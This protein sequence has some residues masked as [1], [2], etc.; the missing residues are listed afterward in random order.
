M[1]GNETVSIGEQVVSSTLWMGSWRW[2]ARL[3]GFV[4][5]II[6]ARLLVPEDFGVLATGAI[7]IG[8]FTIMTGL[9]SDSYLIRLEAPD[10][11]D[12]DT[13]WTLRLIVISIA[14][15]AVFFAAQPGADYFN[16]QRIAA[17]LQVLALT[18]WLG[19][20]VNIGLTIYRRDL[21]FR[22]IAIIG[23]SQRISGSVTTIALAFWLKM[24][25]T[26]LSTIISFEITGRAFWLLQ[27][28]PNQ[29]LALVP[30]LTRC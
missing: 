15:I 26:C 21:Q 22:K 13:A 27:I 17:V 5:T 20:L 2:S 16:D 7:I 12:Y 3:I 9:G 30:F 1:Q 11:D 19:G 18:G 8:F 4:T 29:V 14:S 28:Q 25:I 10:R 23:I 6:L 24:L